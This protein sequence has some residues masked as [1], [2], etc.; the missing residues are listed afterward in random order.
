MSVCACVCT[1][2][3]SCSI[4]WSYIISHKS[5]IAFVVGVSSI[6]DCHMMLYSILVKRISSCWHIGNWNRQARKFNDFLHFPNVI[7]CFL[8]KMQ[9][10][11]SITLLGEWNECGKLLYCDT[12]SHECDAWSY[13]SY[14][15]FFT[16]SLS[17]SFLI[18]NK[19][20]QRMRDWLYGRWLKF[21][22]GK[23]Q[24]AKP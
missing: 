3:H 17:F 4:F 5:A 11:N 21:L 6:S 22:S 1:L 16:H 14:S 24:S 2:F 10:H 13:S 23:L 20:Q 7:L 15:L 9:L 8:P 19:W 18:D 12:K